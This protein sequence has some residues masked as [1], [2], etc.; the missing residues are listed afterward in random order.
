[1]MELHERPST[2]NEIVM[3][4]MKVGGVRRDG[5]ERFDGCRFLGGDVGAVM[6]E[7]LK[8]DDGE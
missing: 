7:V 8:N 5:V 4:K 6:W 1:M 3:W 2:H